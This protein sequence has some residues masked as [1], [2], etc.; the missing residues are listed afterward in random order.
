MTSQ[1]HIKIALALALT[2]SFQA[3]AD[4]PQAV[5]TSAAPVVA[6]EA[7]GTEKF[8][9]ST[10]VAEFADGSK[11]LLS[12]ILENKSKLPTQYKNVP[13]EKIYEIL[14]NRLVDLKLVLDAAV[15]V[16]IDKDGEALKRITDAQ[17]AI[18]QKAYLD[19]EIAKLITDAILSL[20]HI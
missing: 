3:F 16:G 10:V 20:I 18:M 19:K 8:N 12:Q 9:P 2:T 14:L 5:A 13:M 17:E 1:L 4:Q 11:I 7:Q 6:A 15:K